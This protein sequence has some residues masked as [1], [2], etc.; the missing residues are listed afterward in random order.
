MNKLIFYFSLIFLL[1]LNTAKGCALIDCVDTA[2]KHNPEMKKVNAEYRAFKERKEQ[3]RSELLPKISLNVSRSKVNQD[4]SDGSRPKFTQNY[5]TESDSLLLRQP[6]YRPAFLKNYEKVGEEVSAER[7]L[8]LYRT[9]IFTMSVIETYMTLMSSSIEVRLL[10]KKIKLLNEQNL[11][12]EKSLEAGTGTITEKY[13]I[14]ASLDKTNAEMVNAKQTVEMLLKKLSLLVGEDI[15]KISTLN[16][17]ELEFKDIIDKEYVEIE[18]QALTKN[19]QIRQM[20]KRIKALEMALEIEKYSKYPTLDLSLQLARGSS[21]STFFVDSKTYS[22]SVGISLSMPLYQGG[23]LNSRIRQAS[24]SLEAEK[25]ALNLEE[26]RL[27]N[28]LQESFFGLRKN[29][30]LNNALNAAIVS[31]EIDLDSNMKSAIAGVRRQLDVLFSQQRLLEIE[32]NHVVSKIDALLSWFRLCLLM[33][34][35]DKHV[36]LQAERYLSN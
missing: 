20:R 22:Q 30:V 35:L 33:G 1:F 13:E 19:Y 15:K 5:I 29:I 21:E 23:K 2:I 24:F 11:A 6:I 36:F 18:Q 10:N 25:E 7:L 28:E 14:Q 8:L 12:A 3:A 17:K 27:R 4:R 26:H 32:K 16:S 31:A 9:D 34:N